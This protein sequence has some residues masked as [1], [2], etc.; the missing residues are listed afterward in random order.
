[1]NI[2]GTLSIPVTI[3]TSIKRCK[4]LPSSAAVQSGFTLEEDK[5]CVHV[6]RVQ[7]AEN[8]TK[9]R[10]FFIKKL[11]GHKKTSAASDPS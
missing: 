5:S 7:S 3:T 10:N 1:M 4:F 11:A 8:I 6:V 2:T 9:P